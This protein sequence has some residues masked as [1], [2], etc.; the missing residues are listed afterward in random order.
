MGH[1]CVHEQG[2]V[3]TRAALI[4]LPGLSLSACG[5]VAL[6]FRVTG[7]VIRAVPVVGKPIGAPVDAVGDSID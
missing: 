4:L 5:A 7:D 6:P 3:A 1:V 2:D